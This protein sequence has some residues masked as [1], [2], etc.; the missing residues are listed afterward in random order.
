MDLTPSQNGHASVCPSVRAGGRFTEPSPNGS[1]GAAVT[2][3]PPS[4]NGSN[5]C[6][7]GGTVRQREPSRARQPVHPPRC[8]GARLAAGEAQRRPVARWPSPMGRADRAFD[9]DI[10]RP[11]DA[12][13][14]GWSGRPRVSGL[15]GPLTPLRSVRG[16]AK[17]RAALA[18][19]SRRTGRPPEVGGRP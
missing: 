19:S 13:G 5:G 3:K 2:E 15:G 8:P 16:S 6:A 14:R 17:A 1:N 4:P 12:G 10:Q 18:A 11:D 9:G 7:A